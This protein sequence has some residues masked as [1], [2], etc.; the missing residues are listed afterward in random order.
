MNKRQ[1]RK[2]VKRLIAAFVT[3]NVYRL[4]RWKV[5]RGIKAYAAKPLKTLRIKL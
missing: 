4:P 5:F 3:G 2:I 1:H